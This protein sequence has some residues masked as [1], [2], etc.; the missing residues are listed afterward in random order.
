VGPSARL[1]DHRAVDELPQAVDAVIIAADRALTFELA[2]RYSEAVRVYVPH[3]EED[4]YLPPPV[5]GVV[6]ATVALS[7]RQARRIAACVGAGEVVRLRQPVDLRAFAP[8][9]RLAERP[10]RALLLGNYHA[11]AVSR[12]ATI[13]EAWAHA[14]LEWRDLGRGRG[15][16]LDVAEA[17]ADVDIVVGYGRAAVEGMACGR[18]VYI[19]DH[20]GTDGWVTADAYPAIEAGGFAVSTH[21]TGHDTQ[22]I[23]ADLDGYTPE[24]GQVGHELAR[25]HHDARAHAAE[26]IAVIERLR[27]AATPAPVD[28]S[29][30]RSLILLSEAQLRAEGA[31]D[32]SRQEVRRWTDEHARLF[33]TLVTERAAWQVERDAARRALSAAEARYA[34]VRATLRWR[35]VSALMRPFDRLRR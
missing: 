1:G 16:T 28:P 20:S 23:R 7:D 5:P 25:A 4:R 12:A 14:G 21:R 9:A 31:A 24:L 10:A 6:A 19:H 2:D 11:S 13:R 33:Q 32:V 22:R 18:A 26:L 15:P 34:E 29:A 17:M 35:L 3:S 27:P 30:L 8:R